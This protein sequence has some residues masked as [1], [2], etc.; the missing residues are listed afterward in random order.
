M[1][2]SSSVCIYLQAFPVHLRSLRSHVQ[3]GLLVCRSSS[4]H[5]KHNSAHEPQGLLELQGSKFLNLPYPN[6]GLLGRRLCV[7]MP[8]FVSNNNQIQSSASA[9]EALQGLPYRGKN[10]QAHPA[11]LA[12]RSTELPKKSFF[13]GPART[14]AQ[15][16]H[17]VRQYEYIFRLSLCTFA[18]LRSHVQAGLL[19]IQRSSAHAK[20]NSAHEPQGLLE[21]QG[22]KFLNLPYPNPGCSVDVCAYACPFQHRTRTNLKAARPQG[23]RC[24]NRQIVTGTPNHTLHA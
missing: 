3:A 2:H 10:M 24:R 16:C 23:K 8:N 1:P 20:R 7:C 12:Q 11:C 15:A 17:T 6:P 9:G 19:V 14:V 22:S 13:C 21:L 18:S 5:A 4:P